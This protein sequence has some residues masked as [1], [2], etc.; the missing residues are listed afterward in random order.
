MKFDRI[1]AAEKSFVVGRIKADDSRLLK[2]NK[3]EIL[4]KENDEKSVG[5]YSSN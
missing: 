1:R 5:I 2:R 4:I 3:T